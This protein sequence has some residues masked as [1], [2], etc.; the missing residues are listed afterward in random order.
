MRLLAFES[1]GV[2]YTIDLDKLVLGA[3]FFIPAMNTSKVQRVIKMKQHS[4]GM[5]FLVQERVEQ[6]ILGVRVW[7]ML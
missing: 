3:S 7:R 5:R 4:L 2:V 1:S 6:G